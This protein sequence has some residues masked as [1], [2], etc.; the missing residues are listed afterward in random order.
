MRRLGLFN[1]ISLDGYFTDASG[2]MSF[3]KPAAPDPEQATFAAG[4]AGGGG[5][6]V[7]GRVTYQMMAAFWPGEMARRMMPQVAKGMNEN[8]KIV[9][10]R[11][12]K[13]AEWNN[14]TLLSGDPAAEVA[15]LKAGDGPG[16]TVLGSGQIAARLMQAKL[17]DEIQLM[18]IPVVLGAGR[19][20]FEDVSGRPRLKLLEA[21]KFNSGN[22]LLRYAPEA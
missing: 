12:L 20:L 17:F 15:R 4:N 21:R 16:M 18:V 22:V 6:L 1:N 13:A 3:A 10:S 11:T 2:D 14:T 7:F 5:T 8:A 9:F 19:T